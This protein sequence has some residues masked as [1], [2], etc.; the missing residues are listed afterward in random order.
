MNILFKRIYEY[1]NGGIRIEA[2]NKVIEYFD[3]DIAKIQR[4]KDTKI[5]SKQMNSPNELWLT[6][7]L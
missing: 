6:I 4:Y 1:R 5:Q 2:L 7:P 3:I